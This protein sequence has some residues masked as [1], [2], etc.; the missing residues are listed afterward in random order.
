M[1]TFTYSNTLFEHGR[2]VIITAPAGKQMT[3]LF[4]QLLD[5]QDIVQTK[6]FSPNESEHRVTQ[7][8]AGNYS[9][10][11]KYD[12]STQEQVQFA[13]EAAPTQPKIELVASTETTCRVLVS[14]LDASA[15]AYEEG[16]KAA[17]YLVAGPLIEEVEVVLTSEMHI[18]GKW[19]IDLVRPQ[20]FT[21]GLY[22]SVDINASVTSDLLTPGELPMRSLPSTVITVDMNNIPNDPIVLTQLTDGGA[23]G[24]GEEVAF[25]VQ[26]PADAQSELSDDYKLVFKASWLT[27]NSSTDLQGN[28]S[29]YRSSHEQLFEKAIA[30][31]QTEDIILTRAELLAVA[32]ISLGSRLDI[33]VKA[34]NIHGS[35][36]YSDVSSV[37][38]VAPAAEGAAL[39]EPTFEITK[40]HSSSVKGIMETSV[41]LL[42]IANVKTVTD[43]PSSSTHMYTLVESA[44]GREIEAIG[45]MGTFDGQRQHH[46]PLSSFFPI[47]SVYESDQ[48]AIS[49][50]NQSTLPIAFELWQE[51]KIASLLIDNVGGY[52]HLEQ[53]TT[54]IEV[55]NQYAGVSSLEQQSYVDS[56]GIAR[57][58]QPRGSVTFKFNTDADSIVAFGSASP[59]TVMA[60][61]VFDENFHEQ[62]PDDKE[63]YIYGDLLH[64]ERHY[65]HADYGIVH[66]SLP[67][68]HQDRL[69]GKISMAT[70]PDILQTIV[71]DAALSNINP[72]QPHLAHSDIRMPIMTV[73]SD[74]GSATL[75]RNTTVTADGSLP[76]LGAFKAFETD[77]NLAFRR[78]DAVSGVSLS[79]GD[80]TLSVSYST[81]DNL[82]QS[83]FVRYE[84]YFYSYTTHPDVHNYSHT[85][86]SDDRSVGTLSTA[87]SQAENGHNW[88]V[89]VKM[90]TEHKVN[91]LDADPTQLETEDHPAVDAA[92]PR[93]EIIIDSVT[94][95]GNTLS[96]A[97]KPNGNSFLQLQGLLLDITPSAQDQIQWTEGAITFGR[98]G[99]VT[100]TI[101]NTNLSDGVNYY[102]ATIFKGEAEDSLS[103]G[104]MRTNI[105]AAIAQTSY[106]R[107]YDAEES[108]R[109]Y[110][111]LDYPAENINNPH[112]NWPY[113]LSTLTSNGYAPFRPSPENFVAQ[114]YWAQIKTTVDDLGAE[115][116]GVVVMGE[117]GDQER[118]ASQVAIKYSTTGTADGDFSYVGGGS[119]IFDA[120]TIA[121]TPK[122]ILFA[123]P[124]S[125]KYI[126]V[127]PLTADDII[128]TALI[129]SP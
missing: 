117:K 122:E 75:T 54:T 107:L 18:D 3:S 128:R 37:S 44:T 4:Y 85:F 15:E 57:A 28:T 125:A 101:S 72:S 110:S 67:S 88:Y 66:T 116:L 6:Y 119:G 26:A 109:A 100:K 118:Y 33:S 108:Q 124:V 2:S 98:T 83:S 22:A 21:D 111:L 34:Q 30:S 38:M 89:E 129:L 94:K 97:V 71:K 32:G 78:T 74:L 80:Q 77:F 40:F 16:M 120:N 35:T 68:N 90:V 105:S 92:V 49:A 50:G 106:G 60:A 29:T 126:R 93:G 23:I 5:A 58:E 59:F 61:T 31:G 96:V 42:S 12:D 55:I 102:V 127:Y 19:Q 64:I 53:V 41:D 9:A 36:A 76:H 24:K 7:L 56:E 1:A 14:R 65:P 113:R 62:Y 103:V 25:A 45:N 121:S 99:T 20:S 48:I 43:F 63:K 112:L 84:V 11:I 123:A 51:S 27:L 86:T 39:A 79:A 115:V 114:L 8:E 87:L 69:S 52:S 73:S 70:D 91:P 10:L 13:G 17:F 46:S 81:T 47:S 104:A 95:F 82:Y